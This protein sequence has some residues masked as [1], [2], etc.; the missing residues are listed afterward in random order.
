MSG[1]GAATNGAANAVSGDSKVFLNAA[2]CEGPLHT[3]HIKLGAMMV[4]GCD[5]TDDN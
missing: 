5:E 2:W 1:A 3:L 4:L